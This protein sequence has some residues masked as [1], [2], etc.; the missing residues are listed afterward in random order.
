MLQCSRQIKCSRHATR[1]PDAIASF[2]VEDMLACL[3]PVSIHA[4]MFRKQM[5]AHAT[6]VVQT[7]FDRSQR[8]GLLRMIGDKLFAAKKMLVEAFRFHLRQKRVD[9]LE[10]A[11][12]FAVD[13]LHEGDVH[14]TKVQ[15]QIVLAAAIDDA[16]QNATLLLQHLLSD[17]LEN[18]QRAKR[19]YRR[20]GAL[21]MV[22]PN[23]DEMND[24]LKAL[25]A[26]ILRLKSEAQAR[27]RVA[28]AAAAQAAEEERRGTAG[29]L[30]EEEEEEEEEMQSEFDKTLGRLITEKQKQ[31]S[32]AVTG[33]LC[34][35]RS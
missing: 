27:D 34:L 8:N 33:N 10:A 4:H 32:S 22:K 17:A 25:D 18:F 7:Q 14:L 35:C 29:Q 15:T 13:K 5:I 20:T 19:D 9:A 26:R 2:F 21:E 23:L 11:L 16:T 12:E 1:Y 30:E 24:A 28:A 31:E 3:L 6:A